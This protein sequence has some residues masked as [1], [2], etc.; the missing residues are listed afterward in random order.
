MS[1]REFHCTEGSASKFWAIQVEGTRT[2]AQFGKIGS[3][4]QKQIKDFPSEEAAKAAADKL[5]AE[6]LRKGYV[7]VSAAPAAAPAA[8]AP[9]PAPSPPVVSQPAEPPPPST[10]PAPAV[11]PTVNVEPPAWVLPLARRVQ[12]PR[13]TPPSFDRA[14]SIRRLCETSGGIQHGWGVYRLTISPILSPEEARFWLHALTLALADRATPNTVKPLLAQPEPSAPLS[15]AE[16]IKAVESIDQPWWL[17]LPLLNLLSGEDLLDLVA[18]A[19]MKHPYYQ[20]QFA[21]EAAAAFLKQSLPYLTEAEIRALQDHVRKHLRG[22]APS[23]LGWLM[24]AY[25]GIHPELDTH[26]RTMGLQMQPGVVVL[27]SRAYHLVFNLAE[28]EQVVAETRRLKL[29]VSTPDYLSGWLYRTGCKDLDLVRDGILAVGSKADAEKLLNVFC[30]VR[31]PEAAPYMLE[32]QQSARAPGPAKEW[33]SENPVAAIAGLIPVAAGRGKQAEAA[34]EFLREAKRKGMAGAIETQLAR[35]DPE[36]AERIRRDVLAQIEKVYTPFDTTSTPDWLKRIWQPA[37]KLP[38][39]VDPATLPTLFLGEC[40]LNEAQVL[41]VLTE[42]RQRTLT[43]PGTIVATLKQHLPSAALDSFVWKLFERWLSAGA[44]P[45]EKWAFFAVG[46]LGGDAVALRLA[47]LVREWPGESQHQRAVVGLECLR[48]I[49][50]DTALIQLNGIAQKVKFAGLKRKAQEF[51]EAIAAQRGLSRE[52]LEDRIVPD[53]GLDAHGGRVLDF[54]P[55]Q[56]QVVIAPDL[57]PMVRDDSGKVKAD[58]PA[59]GAKDDADKAAAAVAE[60][61]LLKKQLKEAVKVQATRLEQALVSGRCWPVA[62]FDMLLMRHPLQINLVRRLLW[63]AHDDKGKLAK[64]FRVTAE[65]EPAD[66]DDNPCK[67]E[68]YASIGLVHPLRLP[69][70][71]RSCWGQ[72]FAD[73][74]LIEPFPQLN[75]PVYLL[76]PVEEKLTALTRW[77]G[78]AVPGVAVAGRLEKAGWLRGNLH[79]HGDFHEYYK[80]FPAAGLTAVVEVHPGMWASN[81][82]DPTEQSFPGVYLLRGLEKP[83]WRSAESALT[84]SGIDPVVLSEVIAD[85][86][87]A[88]K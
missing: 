69:E 53:L 80:Q 40:S 67:L 27:P 42:L 55:R 15:V 76:E 31:A 73:Y 1:R 19:K 57:K 56:F 20:I 62:E 8:P 41:S 71:E 30:R 21:D 36:T 32:L 45:K 23:D 34:L 87:A 63:G 83:G 13:P 86:I 18:A 82:A 43:A 28:P 16:A 75:R 26:V 47:P 39:W 51:M 44:P 70:T 49:G 79:D 46:L 50:T 81:I 11:T 37:A 78:A 59:P 72:V 64:T 74:E 12:Q 9:A 68:G 6:K 35:T 58:P 22:S 10:A 48:T 14:D 85:L 61:K 60:W 29:T 65:G 3:P 88:S 84:L 52:Q 25:L 24:A 54:G 38:D 33:L 4:G 17:L 66:I 2:T 77:K 5:I 7:E